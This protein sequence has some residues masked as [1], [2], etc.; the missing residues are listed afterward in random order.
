MKILRELNQSVYICIFPIFNLL[1]K[2]PV[3]L[4]VCVFLK[5]RIYM[6]VIPCPMAQP[7]MCNALHLYN[8]HVI[9]GHLQLYELLIML[10]PM[11]IG[12]CTYSH[13]RHRNNKSRLV[14]EL[15]ML[16]VMALDY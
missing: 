8:V 13:G 2:K 7:C 6:Q 11:P 12:N 4:C 10:N 1:L 15:Q 9:G 3:S 14:T 16:T 5:Y